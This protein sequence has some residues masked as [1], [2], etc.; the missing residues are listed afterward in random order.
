MNRL[1][2]QLSVHTSAGF[3]C[4]HTGPFWVIKWQNVQTNECH[5]THVHSKVRN[6]GPRPPSR[7]TRVEIEKTTRAV[8]G[9]SWNKPTSRN[10]SLYCTGPCNTVERAI[11]HFRECEKSKDNKAKIEAHQ[12]SHWFCFISSCQSWHKKI[13]CGSILRQPRKVLEWRGGG[14]DLHLSEW[15]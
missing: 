9:T 12:K 4:R 3:H 14:G 7:T 5:R 15:R 11:P 13:D 10:L 8:G 2:K 1:A 6:S